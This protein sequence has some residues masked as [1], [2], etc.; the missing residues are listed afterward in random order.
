MFGATSSLA[1]VLTAGVTLAT[2]NAVTVPSVN[3]P[4][5]AESIATA[6]A[7]RT[8][9]MECTQLAFTVAD[10]QVRVSGR[11]GVQADIDAVSSAVTDVTG[12]VADVTEV[13]LWPQPF[14][15][16]LD[17]VDGTGRMTTGSTRGP[18]LILDRMGQRPVYR[19]GD[20]IFIRIRPPQTPGHLHIVYFNVDGELFH[21]LPG[22]LGADTAIE[23]ADLLTIGIADPAA[24]TPLSQPITISAPL[25][26]GMLLAV[27][28]PE[29]L[30][31]VAAEPATAATDYIDRLKRRIDELRASGT[32]AGAILADYAILR[33]LPRQDGAAAG[34]STQ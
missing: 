17:L 29:P 5:S 15:A 28:A 25:G 16:A 19:D 31:N 13:E 27:Q 11:V 22:H 18:V 7:D 10:G 4:P 6:L 9:G 21:I 23:T 26:H 32:P 30:L 33:L 1:I 12:S 2:F 14:C 3:K 20:N 24:A 8:A 34:G